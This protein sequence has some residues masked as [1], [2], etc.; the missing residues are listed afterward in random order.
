[1]KNELGIEICCENCFRYEMQ[2]H[3]MKACALLVCLDSFA[4]SKEALEAR[5]VELQA[6]RDKLKAF[7]EKV[8]T[9]PSSDFGMGIC[10]GIKAEARELLESEGGK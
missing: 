9:Y 5:I 10:K 4:P 3:S 1:M 2:N 8:A 7:V 6:A